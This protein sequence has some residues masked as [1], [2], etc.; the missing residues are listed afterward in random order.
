MGTTLMWIS[1]V[2]PAFS[3]KSPN[4]V[5]KPT[6]VLKEAVFDSEAYFSVST[7]YLDLMAC[8]WTKAVV[9]KF[10]RLCARRVERFFLGSGVRTPGFFPI[11][12][13]F[14]EESLTVQN[15]HSI[16]GNELS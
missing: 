6:N 9:V 3:A 12:K 16:H 15:K 2:N 4:W 5:V 14:Q 10:E 8:F 7:C 1:R 13:P 11:P